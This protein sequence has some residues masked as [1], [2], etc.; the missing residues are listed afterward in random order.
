MSANLKKR[1]I[2]SLIICL[3]GL[4]TLLLAARGFPPPRID[5]RLHS[6]IGRALAA[7]CIALL[8]PGGKVTII[9]RD[10]ETFAQPAMVVLMASIQREFDRAGAVV[11]S[12]EPIQLDPI[13]PNEVPAG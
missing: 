9:A 7:E 4:L 5:K 13:R 2:L 1:D 10:T 12:I 11:R 6:E 3:V 8:K